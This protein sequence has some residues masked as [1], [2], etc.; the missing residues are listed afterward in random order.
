MLGRPEV[1]LTRGFT[2]VVKGVWEVEVDC[3]THIISMGVNS[4]TLDNA[5]L[6]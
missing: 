2:V 3:T 4:T 6:Y 5:A 1:V